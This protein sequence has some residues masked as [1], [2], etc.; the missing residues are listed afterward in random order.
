MQVLDIIIRIV[1]LT[2]MLKQSTRFSYICYRAAH[3]LVADYG[4]E[5]AGYLTFL[6]LLA[7]FPYLLVMVSAAAFV[8]QGEEGRQFIELV[9][10]HMP[11]ELVLT[12]RPR[13]VEILSGP[14]HGLLTFAILGAIWTSS[15]AIEGVR[16]VLNRA[17]RVSAPP[18]YLSR[19]LTSIGQVIVLTLLIL[20]VITLLV[21]TPIALHYLTEL[22]GISIPIKMQ[23]FLNAYFVYLGGASL[24]IIVASLYYVLPNLK[25]T[26][27]NV[28][29]GAMLVVFLW[30]SGAVITSFY[31]TKV[32]QLTLVYGSLSGFI[33]TLIFLYVMILIFIYGAEFNHQ[34]IVARG[35]KIE[36]LEDNR[37]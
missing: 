35:E 5:M 10:T 18:R 7:L 8:G 17:Y 20:L 12:I 11:A 3:N 28:I 14:P 34:L 15:S 33:A 26:L 31:L 37:D 27:G 23:N 24:F 4:I 19:R 29:P 21:V 6:S 2:C 16:K 25:Q 1:N 32:S 9:L 22:T 30:V 13:I 36:E